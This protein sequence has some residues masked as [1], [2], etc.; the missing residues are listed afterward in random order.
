ML[1]R[2]EFGS[3]A[4]HAPCSRDPLMTHAS[5]PQKEDLDYIC[6]IAL[7]SAFFD[8]FTLHRDPHRGDTFGRH[9]KA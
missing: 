2:G 7:P 8:Y 6:S 5:F 1:K 9:A 3:P 4:Y